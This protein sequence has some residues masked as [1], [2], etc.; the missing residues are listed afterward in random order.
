VMAVG[1]GVKN[2]KPGDRVAVEPGVPC[3]H[4]KYCKE[5][6]YNLCADI[7]FAATPPVDGTLTRYFKHFADFCFKL[8]DHV[9]Y[10][11][12]AILEPLSVAVHACKRGN[13]SAGQ[14]VLICGAGPIGLVTLLTAKSFGA[15][16]VAIT[17]ITQRR[18]DMAKDMG[19]DVCILIDPNDTPQDT[20]R[21]VREQMGGDDPDVTLEC[22]GA[23][24]SVKLAIYA[25]KSGGCI[26]LV[27]MGPPEIKIPII[28][29]AV[30]E[31]DIKGVFRYR[32]CYPLALWLVSTK[33]I[34]LAPLITHRYTLEDTLD[35]FETA[36]TGAGG[37][38]KVLIA[39]DEA[40]YPE[41][42]GKINP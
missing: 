15:D 40:A 14:K 5:G 23:E 6:F 17:D 33:K 36:R 7:I 42:K 41:T 13:V 30:R 26:L 20:A 37:A 25:T 28:S 11:E 3:R 4:C 9:T 27:G 8:P 16:M 21:K 32:N 31:V 34:D 38:V 35:A 39:C 10:E 12:G 19:A 2:L 22:S 18:L 29:A 1:D 24:S